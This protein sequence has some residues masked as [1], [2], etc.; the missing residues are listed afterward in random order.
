MLLGKCYREHFLTTQGIWWQDPVKLS[1][2]VR[3]SSSWQK[4]ASRTPRAAGISTRQ[5]CLACL[6]WPC[7][8]PCQVTRST[9]PP[10]PVDFRGVEQHCHPQ[11]V[12]GITFCTAE[13]YFEYCLWSEISVQAKGAKLTSGGNQNPLVLAAL[14]RMP[15]FSPLIAM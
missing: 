6:P 4:T 8:L 2:S 5:R 12:A 7:R 9:S 15:T 13:T 1:L 3:A 14:K 11:C 10:P